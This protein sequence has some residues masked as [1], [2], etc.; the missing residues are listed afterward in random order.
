MIHSVIAGNHGNVHNLVNEMEAIQ[1]LQEMYINSLVEETKMSKTRMKK[2][3][4]RK[5]NVYL[6]AEEAVELGI[7]DE[8]I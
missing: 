1:G 6:S 8:I 7:A 5:V 4:E 3:L 2:M